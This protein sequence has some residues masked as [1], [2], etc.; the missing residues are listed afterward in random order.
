LIL[1]TIP[2]VT[3]VDNTYKNAYVRGSGYRY[4]DFAAAVGA[5]EDT[6]WYDNMLADDGVHPATEGAVALYQQV[7]TDVPEITMD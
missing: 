7:L 6:T 1:S 3:A 4:V 5:V 2:L